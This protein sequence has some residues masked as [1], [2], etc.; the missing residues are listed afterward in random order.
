MSLHNNSVHYEGHSRSSSGDASAD[1]NTVYCIH[2]DTVLSKS[3]RLRVCMY[4]SST[5][6][7]EKG[8]TIFEFDQFCTFSRMW[9]YGADVI[10]SI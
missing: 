9:K 5:L 7:T 8:N 2:S 3:S 1:S 10:I 6:P 4:M